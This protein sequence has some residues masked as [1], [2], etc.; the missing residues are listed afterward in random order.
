MK[1]YVLGL[2]LIGLTTN[3]YAAC[4]E[5]NRTY[6]MCKPGYYLSGTICI[7]CPESSLGETTSADQNMSGVRDCY[8]PAGT[9]FSDSTG[10]GTYSENCHYSN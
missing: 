7:A 1:K 3:V 6:V 9:S 4:E 2:I 8:L 10:S 5:T